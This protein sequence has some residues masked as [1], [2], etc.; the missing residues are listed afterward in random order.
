MNDLGFLFAGFAAAWAIAFAYVW[1]LA[2][3]TTDLQ[4]KVDN[5]EGRIDRQA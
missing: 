5:V 3:R 4:H 1:Y 2:K